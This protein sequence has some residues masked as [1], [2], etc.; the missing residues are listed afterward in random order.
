MEYRKETRGKNVFRKITILI[1][2]KI[3]SSTEQVNKT[4]G[5]IGST[6]FKSMLV[7]FSNDMLS[8]LVL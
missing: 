6:Y 8:H 3:S 5:N 4:F 7:L 2:M 1:K